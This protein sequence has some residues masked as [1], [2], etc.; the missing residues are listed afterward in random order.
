[1]IYDSQCKSNTKA[2]GMISSI[3]D[4]PSGPLTGI[5]MLTLS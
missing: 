5:E 1:M 3:E 2:L 4:K